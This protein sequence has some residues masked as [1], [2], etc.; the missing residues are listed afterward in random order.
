MRTVRNIIMSTEIATK[1]DCLSAR[2]LSN[3]PNVMPL[4]PIETHP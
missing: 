2:F 4:N 1:G 3:E